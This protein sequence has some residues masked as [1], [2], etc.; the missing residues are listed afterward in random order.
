MRVLKNLFGD[1]SKIASD[2]III[3]DSADHV[4]LGEMF[5][6]PGVQKIGYYSVSTMAG[7]D[8]TINAFFNKSPNNSF[9]LFTIGTS[10]ALPAP[11]LGYSWLMEGWRANAEYGWVRGTTYNSNG[12]V[13]I[14]RSFFRGVLTD[15][16]EK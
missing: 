5:L 7:L 4:P 8:S 2:E 13:L 6:K 12:I 16:V 10:V 9:F 1:G 11:I 3:G 15:W 14:Y